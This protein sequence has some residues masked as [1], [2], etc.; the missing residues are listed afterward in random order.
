MFENRFG[1]YIVVISYTKDH[2]FGWSFPLFYRFVVLLDTQ[3][4]LTSDS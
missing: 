4:V 3:K 2:R 1:I